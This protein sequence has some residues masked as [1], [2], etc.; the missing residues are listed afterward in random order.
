MDKKIKDYYK[1]EQSKEYLKPTPI[2]ALSL[3]DGQ[4]A[5]CAYQEKRKPK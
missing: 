2:V 3:L 4:I 5:N 1:L